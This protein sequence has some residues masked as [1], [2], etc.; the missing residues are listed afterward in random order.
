MAATV[1]PTI[2]G[3]VE[4]Y[5]LLCERQSA[6]FGSVYEAS[7]LSTGRPY[8]VKVFHISE[9]LKTEKPSLSFCEVPLS[10][11]TF[12]EEMSGHEH[13]MQVEDY[14]KDEHCH[15]IVFELAHGGDLLEELKLRPLGFPEAEAQHLMAQA[16]KGLA[17]L[18][19]RRLAMQDVSLENMLI[20]HLPDGE[21]QIK[22]CDPGQAKKFDVDPTTGEEFAV[23]FTGLVGKSFRPPELFLQQ[24]YL[25]TKVDSWCVGWSTFYML[26][27]QPLFMSCDVAD[28]DA[29]WNLFA[30][31]QYNHLFQVKSATISQKALRFITRLM[32]LD[33]R[34][35]MSLEE[36][37]QHEWLRDPTAQPV[38][39]AAAPPAVAPLAPMAGQAPWA[40]L[41]FPAARLVQQ[42]SLPAA[43]LHHPKPM[44]GLPLGLSQP[45]ENSPQDSQ[46]TSPPGAAGKINT[47]TRTDLIPAPGVAAQGR[48]GGHRPS[49][50]SSGSNVAAT[51]GVPAGRTQ[52][53]IMAPMTQVPMGGLSW[54]NVPHA[55]RA[56]DRSMSPVYALE[57]G[58]AAGRPRVVQV[59]PASP[60][61]VPS[62]R[63]GQA[64]GGYVQLSA[65]GGGLSFASI[66]ALAAGEGAPS[67]RLSG[68]MSGHV[69]TRA[70]SP[71]QP[72]VYRTAGST[73]ANRGYSPGP[74]RGLGA[75]VTGAAAS[76]LQ[77]QS[78]QRGAQGAPPPLHVDANGGGAMVM[79]GRFFASPRSVSPSG[80][81]VA[82]AGTTTT[83]GGAAAR[84]VE[85]FPRGRS[86]ARAIS[87]TQGHVVNAYSPPKG[88][89][90]RTVS[91]GVSNGARTVLSW[92]GA[93]A[94]PS[95][96]PPAGRA[97][98]PMP[99][100]S[101]VVLSAGGGSAGT[102]G[103]PR[104]VA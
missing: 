34:R 14:F 76:V 46:G 44:Q 20:S 2:M 78:P 11:I 57:T 70:T 38:K 63:D 5:T 94:P 25:A 49:V 26:A 39:A 82:A 41:R 75:P 53:R 80:L 102:T 93:P 89:M 42:P 33:P 51:A 69:L 84:A 48:Y 10:E 91:P 73:T 37:L 103:V 22:I 65:E 1:G 18:H 86:Y 97:L 62:P 9:I 28:K 77:Q 23:P 50:G 66:A 60:F 64:N 19:R 56:Q 92:A 68:P 59:R 43:V 96:P 79:P 24:P 47:F 8:A 101:N 72:L 55:S 61:G 15:Y 12:R 4:E 31:G 6:L 30:S 90:V 27:A 7:G 71:M 16:C 36:A 32:D 99:I 83:G 67:G 104:W 88:G 52:S 85:Q 81:Q 74:M 100:Q 35:R 87:P 54:M 13:I 45:D 3:G 21:W 95:P 40:P 29:D 17:E 98:S 58:T